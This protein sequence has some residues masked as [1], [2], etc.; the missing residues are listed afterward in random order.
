M[1]I[2]YSLAGL[3]VGLIVGLTGVGGG[4]LMTPLLVLLFGITPSVAVGTDLLY[5]S[6]T[7]TG[8]ALVH[9]IKNSIQ[10][11]IVGWLALGSIPAALFVVSMLAGRKA[12]SASQE[13]IFSF[14]LGVML[15]L[16][17]LSLV[18]RKP[19]QA[20]AEQRSTHTA[21]AWQKPLFTVLV[22]AFLG[23]AVSLSSVGAGAVGVTALVLLYPKLSA[24]KIVGTDIAHAVPLTLIAGLGHASLGHIDWLLLGSLLLGSLPGVALGSMLST[25]LPDIFV[26]H[27]LVVL[28]LL[29]GGRLVF[30]R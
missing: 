28:L 17:A 13:Q 25:R 3:G 11:K 15:L 30:V 5:A 6:I 22:G 26:R 16:T 2:A 20:W 8:G 10:W 4:S 1:D 29:I 12:L 19:I 23:A 9:G 24:A 21:P 14:S 18:Y 27:S 7:K